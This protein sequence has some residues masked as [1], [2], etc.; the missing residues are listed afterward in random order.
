MHPSHTLH[1]TE[2]RLIQSQTKRVYIMMMLA[3]TPTVN[4]L[5]QTDI[6]V[7]DHPYKGAKA[8][9]SQHGCQSSNRSKQKQMSN[10]KF[11]I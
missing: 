5:N 2:A 6:T 8:M 7:S 3:Q 1:H 9:T 10:Q 11:S 4:R